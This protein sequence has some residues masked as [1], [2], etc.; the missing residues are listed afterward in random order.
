VLENP[1]PDSDQSKARRE[2][3]NNLNKEQKFEARKKVDSLNK[4][5]EVSCL[6]SLPAS[7]QTTT[8]QE[9]GKESEAITNLNNFVK[10]TAAM[11]T[12]SNSLMHRSTKLFLSVEFVANE[13]KCQ[14]NKFLHGWLR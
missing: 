5:E 14:S 2:L 13:P 4:K 10:R 8:Q 12:S 9:S 1:I 11:I 3:V 7:C 6:M